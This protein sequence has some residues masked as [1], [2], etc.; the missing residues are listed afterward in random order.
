[1]TVR[2][3]THR[4]VAVLGDPRKGTEREY[5]LLAKGLPWITAQRRWD[6][7]DAARRRGEVPGL[8]YAVVRADDDPDPRW[9]R[10]YNQRVPGAGQYRKTKDHPQ[11]RTLPVISDVERLDAYVRNISVFRV[12]CRDCGKRI[13]GSGLGIGSHNR[14]CPGSPAQQAADAARKAE[15]DAAAR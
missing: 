15:R 11:F 7:L 10:N 1:M 6:E 8:A 9:N 3:D 12:E 5:I 13:W 14:A 2:T 4:L